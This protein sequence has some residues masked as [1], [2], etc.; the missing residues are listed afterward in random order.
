MN[1]HCESGFNSQMGGDSAVIVIVG[2][3]TIDG[4]RTQRY[5]VILVQ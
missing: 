3:R 5:S 1:P 4:D 2:V